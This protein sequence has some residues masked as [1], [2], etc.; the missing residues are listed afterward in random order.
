MFP[1]GA[2]STVQAVYAENIRTFRMATNTLGDGFVEAINSNTLIAIA[3]MA[4]SVTAALIPVSTCVPQ[5][6]SATVI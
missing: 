2:P 1:P 6:V 3:N 5:D 4:G